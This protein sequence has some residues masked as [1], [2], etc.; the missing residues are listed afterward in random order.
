[1]RE[2]DVALDA[3]NQAAAFTQSVQGPAAAIKGDQSPVTLADYGSQAIVCRA[4]AAAFPND[5][6]MAEEESTQ[7]P[8]I[9]RRLPEGLA[10]WIDVN[11]TTAFVDRF[12][13][14]DPVDGT[15]GFLRGDHYS[16]ALALIV[17]GEVE[18]A[19][20]ACPRMNAVFA[21]VRGGG[22]T[23]S[24]RTICVS[25]QP[26][27][28]RARLCESV[29]SSHS[30]HADSAALLRRLGI[31]APPVRMDSSAKYG[32][33]A[34]GDAE[35]FLRFPARADYQENIWDHAAGALIVSEAGGRVTDLDGK[36]LDFTR[37]PKLTAN[38]GILATNGLLHAPILAAAGRGST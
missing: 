17:R 34:R 9:L 38:R 12:W 11:R 15:K 25:A 3:V 28:T 30:S 19:A 10:R 24:G 4:I 33:V 5:A 22:A 36:P 14:L 16:I 2:L 26:D 20:L 23:A 32:V 35:V 1:M 7:H 8:E 21:A 27:V 37:G 29:E 18:V 31:V 6:I 13:T